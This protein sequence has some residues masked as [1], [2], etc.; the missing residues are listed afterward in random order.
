MAI[1][2]RNASFHVQKTQAFPHSLLSEMWCPFC[3][4]LIYQLTTGLSVLHPTHFSEGG[5]DFAL[6]SIGCLQ[7]LPAAG[8]P[9]RAAQPVAVLGQCCRGERVQVHLPQQRGDCA[10]LPGRGQALQVNRRRDTGTHPSPN[11]TGWLCSSSSLP[12]RTDSCK[13]CHTLSALN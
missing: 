11:P 1:L 3:S 4:F 10:S 12:E 2:R 5:C 8:H 13:P 9:Q 6:L 7:T